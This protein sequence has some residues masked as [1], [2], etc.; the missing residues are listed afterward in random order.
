MAKQLDIFA[1]I[2]QEIKVEHKRIMESS[3]VEKLY[4]SITEV[5]KML[6]VNASHLRFWEK[7]FTQLQPRK[8]GKGD[9]LY[10]KED[11]E[12]LNT[13]LYLTKT[14]KFTLEG[15]REYLKKEKKTAGKEQ[16][17]VAELKQ[18]QSFLIALKQQ[19]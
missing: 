15:T 7:E 10:K 3:P 12:L 13:I 17:I 14:R 5:S 1:Q 18:L 19:L 6:N 2:E 11:I 4:R 8:N 9:R 16:N